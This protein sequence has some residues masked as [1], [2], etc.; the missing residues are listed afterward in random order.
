M[1]NRTTP[2]QHK[3]FPEFA[4]PLPNPI[5]YSIIDTTGKHWLPTNGMTSLSERKLLV[6]LVAEGRNV[7]RHELAHVKWS[8]QRIPKVRYDVR[9]LLAVEDA[10]LNLGLVKIDLPVEL[11]PAELEQVRNLA[12]GD[13]AERDVL[14]FT[15]R[16][17]A[18][19]GTNAEA[20][21]L[22]E[23]ASLKESVR[24]LVFGHVR[25]VRIALLRAR[26]RRGAPVADFRVVRAIAAR[27]ARELDADLARHG[28]PRSLPFPLVLA[29]AGCC[30]GH[31]PGGHDVGGKKGAGEGESEPPQ[32]PSGEMR[33]VVAPLPHPTPSGAGARRGRGRARQEGCTPRHF[34]RWAI[35]RAIF[36][37]SA[38]RRPGGTV[39]VDVSGSMSLDAAGIDS[40]LSASAGAAVVALYSGTDKAGEL[41]IVA[42]KGR[43]A[44]ARDLVPFGR[45]NI[46][47]EPALEWL[48][49]QPGPLLWISD[50]GVTGI[51]DQT[52][53]ALQQRCRE[54]V[55]R[56]GIQRVRTVRE[57][58][59]LLAAGP[60][61]AGA[62]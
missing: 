47:D 15:L 36:R 42:R 25:R 50:G 30:L 29:G 6:P 11:G 7:A 12:R 57:A 35:D 23:L 18:A 52:S 53:P 17:I 41:R 9:Y 22:G 14:G 55:E 34:H 31:G 24:T 45:G 32:L 5:P 40:I 28:L 21:I 19:Q 38:R 8:P 4:E 26:R 54:I 1:H 13:L 33:L 43:R 20:T 44:D 39:L 16:A 61:R 27:L 58:A 56:A 62:A 49:T 37:H 46:V 10:R 59:R 51:G 2:N 60:G 3:P 48:A